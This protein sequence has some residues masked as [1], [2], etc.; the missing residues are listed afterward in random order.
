MK[1]RFIN[2]ICDDLPVLFAGIIVAGLAGYFAYVGFADEKRWNDFKAEHKC[3]VAGHE[4]GHV[5]T[6]IAPIVGGN[7]GVGIVVN[8]T[9]D[10]TGW[11]CDDGI[12]Y[13]R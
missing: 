5:S 12:I 8:N 10:K 6:G 9:P 3:K 2:G 1:M 7:G 11:L 13:W 4:R